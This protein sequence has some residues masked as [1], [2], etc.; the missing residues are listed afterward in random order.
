MTPGQRS[1]ESQPPYLTLEL[2]TGGTR[3]DAIARVN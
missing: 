2:V 3:S 1:L